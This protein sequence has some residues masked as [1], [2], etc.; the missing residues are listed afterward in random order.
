MAVAISWVSSVPA[1][2]TSVPATNSSV[3][4]RT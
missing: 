1:A 2:P 4:P 3:L